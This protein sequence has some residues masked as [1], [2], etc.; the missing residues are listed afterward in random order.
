M[1]GWL[2]GSEDGQLSWGRN[3]VGA[4][5]TLPG[6]KNVLVFDF[7]RNSGDEEG[8]VGSDDSGGGVFLQDGTEWKLA[9]VNFA[10]G[11]QYSRNPDGSEPFM[12]A[13][14]DTRG[15]YQDR[16]GKWELVDPDALS[17]P[18]TTAFASRVSSHVSEIQTILGDG[19]KKLAEARPWSMRTY[20]I[21]ASG[22]LFVIMILIGIRSRPRKR[23]AEQD[24]W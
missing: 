8:T 2:W 17:S 14:Y 21:L 20:A 6:N 11:G 19:Q 24:S 12:A 5:G 7:D 1:K 16:G 13:L 15:L 18:G 3:R 23:L 22:V 4:S 10:S 9:G